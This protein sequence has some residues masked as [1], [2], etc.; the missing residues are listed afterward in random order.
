MKYSKNFLLLS[1]GRIPQDCCLHLCI[2]FNYKWWK[3]GQIGENIADDIRHPC[4]IEKQHALAW[5]WY[6]WRGTVAINKIRNKER[7][8]QN[9]QVASLTSK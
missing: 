7:F 3:G 2:F 1:M 5:Q 4:K 6:D 8:Q 9:Y